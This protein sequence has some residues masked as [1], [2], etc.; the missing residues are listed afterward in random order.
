MTASTPGE[1]TRAAFTAPAAS[2]RNAKL[3][4]APVT[5]CSS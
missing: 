1:L 5:P 2:S 4:A 3:T